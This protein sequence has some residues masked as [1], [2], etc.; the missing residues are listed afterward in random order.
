MDK[1]GIIGL[2]LITAIVIIWMVVQSI[3]QKPI[4]PQE[5]F[6]GVISPDSS[7]EKLVDTSKNKQP[8]LSNDSLLTQKAKDSIALI[9]KYGYFAKLTKGQE[10]ITTI[11]NKYS[12]IQV[13]SKGAVLKTWILNEFKNWY[14][15]PT[16]FINTKDGDLYLTFRTNQNNLIDTRDLYF[17]STAPNKD[18]ELKDNDTLVLNYVLSVDSNARII[19]Q[20][21]FYGNSYSFDQQITVENMENYIPARGYKLVWGEGL[22]FQE[23][24]SVDEANA[25]IAIVSLNGNGDDF[26]AK[27]EEVS[28]TSYTGLV[29]YAAIK[30]KYFAVAIMPLPPKSFDGTIDVSGYQKKLPN[31]GLNKVYSIEYRIPYDGGKHSQQMRVFLGPLNYK[32]TKTYGLEGI[33]DLGWRFGIRQISEYFMLPLFTFIHSFVPNYG[34]A[35]IIFGVLIKILLYPLSISQMKSAQKMQVIAPLMT[36]IREK[37]K[38]DQQKQ[39]KEIMK[40]YSDY[41]INPTGGCLPLLIQLPILYALFSVLRNAVELRQAPFIWWIK[42]LS[43]PDSIVKFGFSFLGINQI[44]GLALLM[45]VALF[46]Q[47]RMSITDP[48]QKSMV[49]IMPVFMTLLF[50]Y[51][52]SGLNLYYL[53]FNILSI[54]VQVYMNKY[55]KNKLTL[56]DLKKLPK[57]EGWM[58]KKMREAQEIAE[59]QGRSIPGVQ[60]KPVKSTDHRGSMPRKSTNQFKS[61]KK[62]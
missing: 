30:S 51:L 38:D 61:P 22:R 41:G 15:G 57:K 52:P 8:V 40:L 50:N 36:E 44:S 21:R 23:E 11:K 18:F 4:P 45:G 54:G 31:N 3:T 1:K 13:S 59:S 9:N 48:R 2:L 7:Q 20:M 46:F 53:T 55:S 12:T 39:Q 35:I 33:I 49:Y 42:D 29:D 28:Q 5:K 17:S 56:A 27:D 37:Y 19:K 26:K 32:L 10:Q 62:K 14:G 16:Q 34:I 24:N 43:V 60:N 58:Q 6:K 25:S 47:Q